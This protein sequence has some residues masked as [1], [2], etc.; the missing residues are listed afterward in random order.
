MARQ[1]GNKTGGYSLPTADAAP[2]SWIST[3]EVARQKNLTSWPLVLVG[4]PEL[5]VGSYIFA[6]SSGVADTVQAGGNF[7]KANGGQHSRAA[8]ADLFG[9]I[10]TTYGAGDGSTT[11]NV[12]DIS[13]DVYRY[14]KTTTTSG[15]ILAALS[16]TAVLPSH[17]HSVYGC[18]GT[19]GSQP[20][21]NNGPPRTYMS[22]NVFVP[23]IGAVGSTDG[24]NGRHQQ[25]KVLICKTRTTAPVGAVFPVLLPINTAQFESLLPENLLIPSG[26]DV[27][28][29]G[30]PLLFSYFDTKFGPGDGT[31]TFGL[32][33]L[34]GLFLKGYPDT[35]PDSSGVLSPN[36]LPDGFARHT[37]T[38]NLR[39]ANASQAQAAGGGGPNA[40][41]LSSPATG[42]SSVGTGSENMPSNISVVWVLVKG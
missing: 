27:E 28:R 41:Y 18:T 10:G 3:T 39:V 1:Y 26:Q 4:V 33:D 23:D 34:R 29:A 11:F 16:G 37:H 5:E 31:T 40:P 38:V 14:L 15:S 13:N 21:N 30:N 9:L 19:T 35:V 25:A 6:L 42:A 36:Y 32:P 12:P 2:G 8:E 24:N 20:T 7:F 17:T 22:T